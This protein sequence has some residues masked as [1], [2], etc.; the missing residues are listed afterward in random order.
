MNTLYITEQ[1]TTLKKEGERIK[2]CKGK[3]TI[4]DI[5]AFKI[6]QIVLFG[7][8]T[9]TGSTIKLISDDNIS[10][11]YLTSHGKYI[12]SFQ[13]NFNKNVVLRLKQYNDHEDING[14]AL[15]ISKNIVAG[16]I[17]NSRT[18]IQKYLGNNDVSDVKVNSVVD[19]LKELQSS[20]DKTDNLNQLL[21]VE[22]S[23]AIQ[24]F[25]AFKNML[26]CSMTFEG[27]NRR[28]PKDP[29]N[30]LLSLGYTLLANDITTALSV[31]GLDPYAGFLHRLRYGRASLAL[32][33]EEEFRA[34]FVDRLVLKI[35]NKKIIKEEDFEKSLDQV[36]LKRE[37]LKVFLNEYENK[38]HEEI[39]HPTFGYK[40][41]YEECFF[42]QA[43][44]M[45][46]AIL[47]NIKYEPFVIR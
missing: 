6:N 47:E 20:V 44:L 9:V 13:K 19:N 14:K 32:D 36:K 16:K 46:K 25:S 1:Y 24:Y 33:V 28:P 42:I 18:V 40:K 7:E 43:K 8:V 12:G 41:T 11:A 4:L 29:V 26:K 39:I 22:G 45:S 2:L 23:A 17:K 30:A 38:K 34:S 27:R 37:S 3:D 5:P 10:L 35:L 21:G 31:T 15:D